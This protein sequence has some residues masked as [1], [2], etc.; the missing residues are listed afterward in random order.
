MRAVDERFGPQPSGDL[1]AERALRPDGIEREVNAEEIDRLDLSVGNIPAGDEPA[2]REWH[3]CTGGDPLIRVQS[4][5]ADRRHK[6]AL[7]SPGHLDLSGLVI[8]PE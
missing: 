7:V 6:G 2:L 3:H 1:V 4:A 5:E 8:E